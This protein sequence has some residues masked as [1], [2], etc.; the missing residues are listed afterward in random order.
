M[1]AHFYLSGTRFCKTS[2]KHDH[3]VENRP[4]LYIL[5]D[6]HVREINFRF[7]FVFPLCF[8]LFLFRYVWL[9]PFD[10]VFAVTTNKLQLL[11]KLMEALLK[12]P[13]LI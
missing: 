11:Y 13:N 2:G 10:S 12:D 4:D 8:V 1:N 9:I 3:G 7:F 5:A 6:L